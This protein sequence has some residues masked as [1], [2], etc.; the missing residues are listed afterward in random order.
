MLRVFI[1]H[2]RNPAACAPR[3][4][5]GGCFACWSQ[6]ETGTQRSSDRCTLTRTLA[7]RRRKLLRI[8]RFQR[9]DVI[10]SKP[11]TRSGEDSSHEIA[12]RDM[13]ASQLS[14]RRDMFTTRRFESTDDNEIVIEARDKD[15]RLCMCI[16]AVR[17]S[18]NPDVD[19]QARSARAILDHRDR[20]CHCCG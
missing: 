17:S 12:I 11:C 7:D 9:V 5:T 15:R 13:Q 19:T 10:E 8:G 16:V 2:L 4:R 6:T 20:C 3:E 1:S 14:M 18:V